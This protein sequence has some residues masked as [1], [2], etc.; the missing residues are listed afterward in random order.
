MESSEKILASAVG[1]G[2]GTIGLWG[3][4]E[5]ATW[6]LGKHFHNDLHHRVNDACG[7]NLNDGQWV[8]LL[9][10]EDWLKYRSGLSLLPVGERFWKMSGP[11]LMSWTGSSLASASVRWGA[12]EFMDL[13]GYKGF[14]AY[15]AA[16]LTITA[17]TW[18]Y[19]YG[20]SNRFVAIEALSANDPICRTARAIY[21]EGSQSTVTGLVEA[22]QIPEQSH[23][24]RATMP[25]RH[26]TVRD[27]RTPLR[28]Y[29]NRRATTLAIPIF[30]RP[31]FLCPAR[32]Y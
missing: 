24:A 22:E 18:K 25:P 28:Y 29:A 8:R 3:S 23:T 31:A 32:A 13:D 7:V 2:V 1:V 14:L 26:T 9:G 6:Q 10:T 21:N 16:S 11:L 4:M 20:M 27:R 5:Y 15:A 19:F 30:T 17:A 12:A